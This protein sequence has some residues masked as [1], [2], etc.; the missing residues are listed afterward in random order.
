MSIPYVTLDDPQ[1]GEA[2]Q[3]SP[4]VHAEPSLQEAPSSAV[5]RNWQPC[6]P[7]Q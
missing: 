4:L 2:V 6:S 7:S 5:A 1:Y 3:V